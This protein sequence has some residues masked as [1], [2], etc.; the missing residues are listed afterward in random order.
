LVTQIREQ[1]QARLGIPHRAIQISCTHSHSTPDTLGAGFENQEYLA[2]FVDAVTDGVC[3][4]AQN[5]EPARLGWK[6]VPIRGLAH[7]RRKK[8]GNAKVFTTRYGVPSTWRVKPELIASEGVIDPD[9]TVIRIENLTGDVIAVISNFGCHASVA[10]MSANISGDFPGEA[11]AILEG[12]WGPSSVV[13]CT[14]GAAADVDPTFEMPY[15]GPRDDKMATHLGR[16]FAAQV[17]EC[18]ER[19]EV[20]D[21]SEVGAAQELVNLDVRPDWIR[22]IE[23]EQA[24]M[25]Q[26]FSSGWTLSPVTK[27]VLEERIIK[28][29]V[30]A[31]R[32]GGL[33]LIGF[34][35]EV[36]AEMG[37]RLKAELDGTP[38][39]VLE[40]TNDDI[41][42]IVTQKA[43]REGGY[44]VD[45]HFWGRVKSEEEQTLMEAAHKV[46]GKLFA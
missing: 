29:E 21:I 2:F 11:M 15:W 27:R 38:V 24:R 31:L 1:V 18:A 30:Q 40:L 46:V 41:G 35:G 17:L 19:A 5:L 25:Q 3:K 36:F 28:T 8:M 20:A 44:E 43:C 6:K 23:K 7:S 12:V 4:A 13:L 26:E 37:L 39:A 16:I 14:N 32:M 42:Y 9:L 10:L 34:P 22:L 45:Q 33:A